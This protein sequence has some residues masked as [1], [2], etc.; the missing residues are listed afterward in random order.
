[1][2][3]RSFSTGTWQ[4]PWFEKLSPEAKLLFIYLWTNDVC[5]QAGCYIISE[6]R[7]EFETGMKFKKIF[8]E[9]FPK[10]IW[11]E[12]FSVVWVK[13]FFRRQCAN[14]KFA[15][16]A[17]RS[18][19]CI[20]QII[21]EEFTRH[22]L[23]LIEKHGIDTVSIPYK[24]EVDTVCESV[25]DQISSDTDTGP[26]IPRTRKG[27]GFDEFWKAYPKKVGKQEAKR[28]WE[29]QNGNMPELP[30]VISKINELK[31]SEQ[32]T[33]QNGQFIPNPATWLNRGGWDD[34]VK[35]QVV[36]P[37][38]SY[39]PPNRIEELRK[40]AIEREKYLKGEV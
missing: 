17:V 34:E 25:T 3:Y 28:A 38:A 31:T 13:A 4:D 5:N 1:M 26:V 23:E 19:H 29:K 16:A 18:L 6:R 32:W 7:I 11:F 9:L 21:V 35:I 37:Q 39:T 33:K 22:N 36:T 10:V 40:K 14:E 30:T 24:T 15:Y 27:I 12:N 8:K 2:A 20:P